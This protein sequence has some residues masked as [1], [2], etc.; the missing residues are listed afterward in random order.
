VRSQIPDATGLDGYSGYLLSDV[1]SQSIFIS[2]DSYRC[3]EPLNATV[4]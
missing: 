1:P 2:G 4:G 3:S